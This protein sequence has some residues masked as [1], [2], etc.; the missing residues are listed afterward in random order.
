[1]IF[2]MVVALFIF[3]CV[4]PIVGSIVCIGGLYSWF[5]FEDLVIE[6]LRRIVGGFNARLQMP[7]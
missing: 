5:I 2:D 7:E 3:F 1:M 4:L 6:P